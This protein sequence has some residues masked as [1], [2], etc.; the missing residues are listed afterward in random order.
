MTRITLAV[1]ILLT[2]AGIVSAQPRLDTAARNA[3][4]WDSHERA[5][6][7]LSTAAVAGALV[8]PCLMD[9]QWVCVKREGVRV[10]TALLAAMITKHVFPR[11]RPNGSDDKSF[12][13]QHTA[14]T[15]AAVAGTK[16][17]VL[18]P[19]VGYLRISA[20]MHWATDTMVGGVV[21][22]L[23]WTIQF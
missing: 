7:V 11:R 9:R 13:S 12:F 2:F 23:T 18:C 17:W 8:A 6:D 14:L 5:A 20:D 10:G 21:G 1:M 15:C 19:A 4:Q 22:G 3:L 16:V